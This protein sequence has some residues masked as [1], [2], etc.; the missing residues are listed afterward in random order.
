MRSRIE[1]GQGPQARSRSNPERRR[2]GCR[3]PPGREELPQ[4]VFRLRS[5][6]PILQT[7]TSV[8]MH[9]TRG[10]PRIGGREQQG[11]RRDRRVLTPKVGRRTIALDQYDRRGMLQKCRTVIPHPGDAGDRSGSVS[12][13]RCVE[14]EL[15]DDGA[16]RASRRTVS[17][18]SRSTGRERYLRTLR[19]RRSISLNSIFYGFA[20]FLRVNRSINFISFDDGEHTGHDFST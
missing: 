15:R 7:G 10:Q 4:I 17:S 14:C 19:R 5:V 13:R 1:R 16:A 3:A 11:R 2:T 9:P 12:T 8:H 6:G 20:S 18:T